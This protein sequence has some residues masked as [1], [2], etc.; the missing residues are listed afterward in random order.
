MVVCVA[1]IKPTKW[2]S[3]WDLTEREKEKLKE[4]RKR[5]KKK[6]K[7]SMIH[8]GLLDLMNISDPAVSSDNKQL[9]SLANKQSQGNSNKVSKYASWIY[10]LFRYLKAGQGERAT[11]T[12][13]LHQLTS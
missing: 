6:R 3:S 7:K 1:L 13:T 5:A 4:E 10:D 11:F 9:R 12:R 2:K 8:Q